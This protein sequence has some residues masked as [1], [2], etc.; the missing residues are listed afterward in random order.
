MRK[1]L[2]IHNN[3]RPQNIFQ[4][5]YPQF[6]SPGFGEGELESILQ[7]TPAEFQQIS[8]QQSLGYDFRK[9]AIHRSQIGSAISQSNISNHL[10]Q[11]INHTSTSNHLLQPKEIS[12][13]EDE[14]PTIVGLKPGARSDIIDNFY[15]NFDD[16][17][18]NI[19]DAFK[20]GL[21]NFSTAMRFPPDK[22]AKPDFQKVF[23]EQAKSIVK[24]GFEQYLQPELSASFPGLGNTF[25]L[26]SA[27][28]NEVGRAQ[29]VAGQLA[30]RD[31]LT[32]TRSSF[33]DAMR[34][35][36]D[37]FIANAS[38]GR[39]QAQNLWR[40]AVTLEEQNEITKPMEELLKRRTPS[41]QDFQRKIVSAYIKMQ[42]GKIEDRGFFGGGFTSLGRIEIKYDEANNLESAKIQ[43][44]DGSGS[45]QIADQ[46]NRLYGAPM[47]LRDLNVEIAVGLY[48]EN[49][50]GGKSYKWVVLRPPYFLPSRGLGYSDYKK[51]PG[52]ALKVPRISG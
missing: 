27:L 2:R 45:A 35:K 42:Q 17:L 34:D 9:I 44:Q 39:G 4:A 21:L 11:E 19:R 16:K 7:Q 51:F 41:T 15:A 38:Q 46:I 47:N 3:K 23:L 29:K 36:I 14:V 1:R 52:D 49:F 43:L 25:S 24:G 13:T 10:I 20:D 22:N 6:A 30:L 32:E 12:F 48:R 33:G 18:D 28:Q 37:E 40:E 8:T 5:K 31:F 26:V 50:V